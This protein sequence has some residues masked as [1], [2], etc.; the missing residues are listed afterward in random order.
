MIE[1]FLVKIIFFCYLF[2]A[3]AADVGDS[4]DTTCVCAETS[5]NGAFCSAF[6]CQSNQVT[7]CFS[8]NS[9]VEIKSTKEYKSMN[10]LKIGDEILVNINKD[11]Q[12][13]YEPIYSF[14]HANSNGTY[15]YLKISIENNSQRS[16]I[17][18][19]NHL[20]YRYNE[21]N[22]IF[23]GHLKIGDQLQIISKDGSS[24][25]AGSIINI[26]LI[27][28]Q[29]YYAP[30]TPCGKLI[31]DGIIVSNYATVANHQLAHLAMQ[32]YRWWVQWIGSSS[33]SESIHFYCQCLYF[34]VEYINKW[35]F[36]IG[37]YDGVLT[38]TNF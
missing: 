35:F 27:K 24:I 14:I 15:E 12:R 22:P 30:L 9:T 2:Q 37:L 25:Q 20:I 36:P 19:S 11:G 33:Y 1:V 32:P 38:I 5:P 4:Y 6:K 3:V 10:E 18:S 21:I 28:S 29:G 13:I 34:I 16:L 17:I 23:A 8:S 31:V 26:K 7:H